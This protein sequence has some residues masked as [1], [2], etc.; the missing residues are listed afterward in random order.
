MQATPAIS[1]EPCIDLLTQTPTIKVVP[2]QIQRKKKYGQNKSWG[3]FGRLKPLLITVICII[4]NQ[5][6]QQKPS[7]CC[8]FVREKKIQVYFGVIQY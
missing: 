7:I 8:H 6:E 4:K 2:I 3:I 1:T 5:Q